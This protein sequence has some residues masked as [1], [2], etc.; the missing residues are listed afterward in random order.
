[1]YYFYTSCSYSLCE[2]FPIVPF[3]RGFFMHFDL[4]LLSLC[5]C[6]CI[7]ATFVYVYIFRYIRF[8]VNCYYVITI[9]ILR[10]T[11]EHYV[12][13]RRNV[14]SKINDGERRNDTKAK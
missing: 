5:L 8:W 1:M 2:T 11:I 10:K 7:R 9:I 12:T 4:V 3:V 6:H 14:R 13:V